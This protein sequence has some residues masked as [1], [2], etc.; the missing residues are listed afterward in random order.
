MLLGL[1][2]C[3]L[4]EVLLGLVLVPEQVL[5]RVGGQPAML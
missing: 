3:L 4:Q 5:A 2:V 1:R